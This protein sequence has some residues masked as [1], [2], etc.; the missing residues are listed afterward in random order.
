MERICA[1]CAT[2]KAFNASSFS[3]SR[4]G[5]AARSRILRA[6]CQATKFMAN[7]LLLISAY[8][9]SCGVCVRTGRRQSIPSSN[10][11][12]WARVSDTV[13]LVACGQMKRPRSSRFAKRRQPIAVPP[14][15]LDQISP[16]ST[17][18]KY[19]SRKRILLKCRLHHAT[20]PRKT[21]PQIRESG[22]DPDAC[23]G[24]SVIIRANTP[25]RYAAPLLP[26]YP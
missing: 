20:Q 11:D 6:V 15:H 2:I 19:M 5:R 9:A 10:I 23:P 21:T 12:N 22:G 26:H 3:V 14:Q 18:H 16:P 25:T 8:T 1:C 7:Q 24:G 13:A 4:S 17:K